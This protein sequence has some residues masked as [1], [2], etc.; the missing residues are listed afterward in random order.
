MSSTTIAWDETAPADSRNAGLGASDIRSILTNTRGGLDSEHHWP[1]TAGLHGAH[2]AGSARAYYGTASQVSS[3][4]TDGRFMFTSDTSVLFG[5]NSS[6]TVP[7]GGRYATYSHATYSTGGTNRTS[8]VTQR[9]KFEFGS[10]L[11]TTGSA[12]TTVTF[13]TTNFVFAPHVQITPLQSVDSLVDVPVIAGA[14]ATTLQVINYKVT[15]GASGVPAANYW[16]DYLAVG[17]VPA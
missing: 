4:D 14:A 6:T 7:L 9:V 17:Y 2:R 16:V 10:A 8:A 5:V 1:S 3:V 13:T 15:S 11:L 12:L